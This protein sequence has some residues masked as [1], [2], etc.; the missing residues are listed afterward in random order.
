MLLVLLGKVFSV[1]STL[2]GA[3]PRTLFSDLLSI[4]SLTTLVCICFSF[5]LYRVSSSTSSLSIALILLPCFKSSVFLIIR[6]G[7]SVGI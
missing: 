5:T 2:G 7:G 6:G 3:K 4:V 1:S